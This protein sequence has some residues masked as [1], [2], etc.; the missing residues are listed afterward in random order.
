MAGVERAE[1][2]LSMEDSP[3]VGA[4]DMAPPYPPQD[5]AED[6]QTPDKTGD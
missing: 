2:A 3:L 5:V 6:V 1:E 4:N